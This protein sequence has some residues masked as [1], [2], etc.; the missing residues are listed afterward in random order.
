M[1]IDDP[2][3]GPGPARGGGD[4]G[5]FRDLRNAAIVL[6]GW[7][8]GRRGEV[9]PAAEADSRRAF[10]PVGLALGLAA[11]PVAWAADAIGLQ[12]LG[13][14]VFAALAV[15][16]LGNFRAEAGAAAAAADLAGPDAGA[17]RRVALIAGCVGA[18]LLVR[19]AGLA[20][21]AP[22][23]AMLGA[24]IAAQMLSAAA[25]ALVTL[26]GRAGHVRQR[27]DADPLF[28]PALDRDGGTALWVSGAA[29]LLLAIL[30]A[31]LATAVL[32]A[33]FC[34]AAVAAIWLAA[35]L[36]GMPRDRNFLYTVRIKTEL[37]V[38][39]AAAVAA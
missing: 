25:M 8:M 39:L 31:G 29:A 26:A 32:A 22:L 16:V 19:V 14:A 13:A 3:A 11:A 17:D 9:G 37:A 7:P 38:I 10:A 33:L 21:L 24:L 20:V 34:L 36:C 30:F 1:T 27:G 4:S 12:A 23:P 2:D 5:W 15:A 28:D 35:D 18:I 6:T